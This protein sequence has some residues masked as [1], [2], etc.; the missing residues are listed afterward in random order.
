M[1]ETLMKKLLINST[2]QNVID[3]LLIDLSAV[4]A[5]FVV[6]MMPRVINVMVVDN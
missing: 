2:V 5:H 1:P 4:L 6:Q 3:S